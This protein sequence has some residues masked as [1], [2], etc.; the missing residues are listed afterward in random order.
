M[1]VYHVDR[2]LAGDRA[3]VAE[4]PTPWASWFSHYG[5]TFLPDLSAAVFSEDDRV[6]AVDPAG[7]TR[8]EWSHAEHPWGRDDGGAVLA[9]SDGTQVWAVVPGVDAQGKEGQDLSGSSEVLRV[10][11][12]QPG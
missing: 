12:G 2:L 9:S 8:W 6:R 10:T 11:A 5:N 3:P 4:F 1:R 7:G